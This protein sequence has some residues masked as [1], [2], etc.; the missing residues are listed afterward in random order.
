MLSYAALAVFLSCDPWSRLWHTARI[1]DPLLLFPLLAY[2]QGGEKK[3]L[4][5]LACTAPVSL[6]VLVT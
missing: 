5:P 4:V 6:Y 2:L 1:L 3:L